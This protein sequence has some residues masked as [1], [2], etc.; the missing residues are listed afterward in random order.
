MKTNASGKGS[1]SSCLD[2][3]Q[4]SIEADLEPPLAGA[5]HATG[6]VNSSKKI[7]R[8]RGTEPSLRAD[9]LAVLCCQKF[10]GLLPMT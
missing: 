1:K 10:R 2:P 6:L 3:V 4:P 5:K 7:P 8:L 9:Q